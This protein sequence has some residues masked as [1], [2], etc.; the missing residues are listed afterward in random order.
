MDTSTPT[1]TTPYTTVA[2][3]IRWQREFERRMSA[4]E[5]A[6]SDI[7]TRI[8]ALADS[9]GAYSVNNDKV[10]AHLRDIAAVLRGEKRTEEARHG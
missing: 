3:I 6:H 7:A 5:Q 8:D 2:D 10:R 1:P 4:V 9:I